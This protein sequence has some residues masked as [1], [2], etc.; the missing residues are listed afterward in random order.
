MIEQDRSAKKRNQNYVA[1]N[2]ILFICSGTY[3][4]WRR[5]GI[6]TEMPAISMLSGAHSA[7]VARYFLLHGD[8]FSK[9]RAIF[10]KQ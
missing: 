10:S 5:V 2:E 4:R 3:G 7:I 6:G 8:H 9:L 1:V